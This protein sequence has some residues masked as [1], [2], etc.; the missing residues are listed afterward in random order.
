MTAGQPLVS[1][2][3]SVYNKEKYLERCLK[4]LSAQTLK[5]IEIIVINDG[6]TDSSPDIMHNYAQKEP[7]MI[8]IDQENAGLSVVRNNGLKA[9]SGKYVIYVDADDA[10]VPETA[11]ELY[12]IAERDNLDALFFDAQ[13]I[14]E[15]GE[16]VG[17]GWFTQYI[18]KNDYSTPR[19]GCEL[20]AELLKEDEYV[21]QACMQMNNREYML[22]NNIFF[23]PGIL[24][25]DNLF[26]FMNMLSA[27]R[28]AHVAKPYYQRYL[29]P[30]SIMMSKYKAANLNGYA[31]T[32]EG[33]LNF[34]RGKEFDLNAQ[35]AIRQ[36][37]SKIWLTMHNMANGIEAEEL[38]KLL[39]TEDFADRV[40]FSTLFT[41]WLNINT[42][43]IVANF[44]GKGAD[45]IAVSVIIPVYNTDVYLFDC[46]DSVLN[47]SLKNIE[48]ICVDDG[49]TD[50]SL[51]IL[52][53]YAANDSRVRIL[54][55]KNQYAGAARNK[56]IEAAKGEY[57][58]FIDSDDFI[59]GDYLMDAYQIASKFRC[60]VVLSAM[61]GYDHIE[62]TYTPRPWSLDQ[63]LLPKANV[64]SPDD[65]P[66]SILNI[67]TTGPVCKFCRREFVIDNNIR[68]ANAK[69]SEDMQFAVPLLTSAKRIAT[70]NPNVA[71]YHY[72]INRPNSLES[73]K[74][75]DP[76]LLLSIYE[77]L[78]NEMQERGLAE[79]Y[80]VSFK[81]LLLSSLHYEMHSTGLYE[82]YVKFQEYFIN[83]GRHYF[84]YD[85]VKT[86]WVNGAS[87][88]RRYEEIF[89][90]PLTRKQFMA[91]AP[92][93]SNVEFGRYEAVEEP[94]VSVIL[95]TFNVE[96]YINDCLVSLESQ[97]E[98]N[99]EIIFVDDKCT[100]RTFEFVERYAEKD[101]RITILHHEENRFAGI[102][103]NT[104]MAVAK[105]KYLLFLDPDDFYSRDLIKNSV[106][107]A[108]ETGAD[109]CV[110]GAKSY[111]HMT[112]AYSEMPH[113]YKD[114]RYPEE[115]IFT[116][117]ENAKH[118]FNFTSACPWNKL[119]RRSFVEKT[120]LKY[121]GTR[122]SN[123][124]FFVLSSLGC[125]EK[126]AILKEELLFYRTNVPTSLQFTKAKEP[127]AFYR[128]VEKFYNEMV[129]RG[130]V[131]KFKQSIDNCIAENIA[132]NLRTLAK[133]EEVYESVFRFLQT[134]GLAKLGISIDDRQYYYEELPYKIIHT[135]LNDTY[136]DHVLA[137]A[138]FDI[139]QKEEPLPVCLQPMR[140]VL[141]WTMPPKGYTHEELKAAEKK[142]REK[143]Y[144][145][146][147]EKGI[148][149]GV[150]IAQRSVTFKIGKAIMAVPRMLIRLIKR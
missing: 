11:E 106:A 146:G 36:A 29:V 8:C 149:D 74:K 55:Q 26:T 28:A 89:K 145:K 120:G 72:R 88:T 86:G 103:R 109:V 102:A 128:A 83:K 132:F 33:M 94:I 110:F 82:N 43:D 131:W 71:Y 105:G 56:G 16:A 19:K 59:S 41:R 138:P 75:E 20:M 17:E 107:C 22:N 78:F 70:T 127:L 54:H 79:K 30:G 77:N 7:R 98:K 62:H 144:K 65:I 35:W 148:E 112:R 141:P 66:E 2:I 44:K 81:N 58:V 142:A 61:D 53:E 111:N 87:N 14:N 9:A 140:R 104:G 137:D 130:L 114:E 119:F 13:T 46:L 1:F 117:E 108:E 63:R 38:F 150:I 93:R 51:S 34:I 42:G 23:M 24:H 3:V 99:I 115:C 123:D 76:M 48:V 31:R 92:I 121:Q 12:A 122:N 73:T 147:L 124:L 118:I 91:E 39:S 134:E 25:E 52:E 136:E 69:R 97:S 135:L 67:V 6:S 18:R 15:T 5:E 10:F 57:I 95:P 85:G 40:F 21:V 96:K 125:A 139:A 47:Q 116:P 143:G 64:F 4:S 129:E 27:E 113:L 32:F 90:R 50:S 80:S 126:V 49:S 133:N 45:D 100:D 68:F 37:I 101:K 60:D 84:E